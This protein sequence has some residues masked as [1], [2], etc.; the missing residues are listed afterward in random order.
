MRRVICP[1][2]PYDQEHTHDR[3]AATVEV[4]IVTCPRCQQLIAAP[5]SVRVYRDGT[6]RRYWLCCGVEIEGRREPVNE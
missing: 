6:K 2:C 1:L 3:S 4:E 5:D